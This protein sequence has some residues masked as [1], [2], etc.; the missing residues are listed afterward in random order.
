MRAALAGSG[1]ALV[2][3]ADGDAVAALRAAAGDVV[4]LVIEPSVPELD[5]AMLLAA[6]GPLAVE[7]APAVRIAALDVADGAD[8][9]DVVA[10]AAFLVV[11]HSTTGQVLRIAR[12]GS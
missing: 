3:A 8:L 7:R 9:A 5:K 10:A 4:L 1:A 2:Y 11:A 6:I 12:D